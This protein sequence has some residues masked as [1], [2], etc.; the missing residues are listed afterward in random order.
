MLIRGTRKADFILY[1]WEEIF[2]RIELKKH[3]D[4]IFNFYAH[5]SPTNLLKPSVTSFR[6]ASTGEAIPRL[7][8]REV[9]RK[10]RI[11]VCNIIS[12][13]LLIF[14]RGFAFAANCY[15]CVVVVVTLLE[16]GFIYWRTLA[17]CSFQTVD[18]SP[19]S[20]R[21][22]GVCSLQTAYSSPSSHLSMSH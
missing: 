6:E 20:S 5:F 9:R 2:E 22:L 12:K 3:F 11:L 17:V 21:T 1:W 18:S 13:S 7:R 19:S 4:T 10:G 15:D 14:W 8:L 16:N